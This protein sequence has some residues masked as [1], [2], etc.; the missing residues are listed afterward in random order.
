MGQVPL[1]KWTKPH[2]MGK[3]ST[4][5]WS[6]PHY[7]RISPT[8]SI[9]E[10]GLIMELAGASLNRTIVIKSHIDRVLDL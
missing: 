3:T 2:Y 7:S 5:K 1:S 8:I 4:Y 10:Q 9:S 6:K